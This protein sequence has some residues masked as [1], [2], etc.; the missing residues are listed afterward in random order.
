MLIFKFLPHNRIQL[1]CPLI[2]YPTKKQSPLL[3]NGLWLEKSS[4]Y[5]RP[6][7]SNKCPNKGGVPINWQLIGQERQSL[8][9]HILIVTLKTIN[10]PDQSITDWFIVIIRWFFVDV[11]ENIR[12]KMC[13]RYRKISRG[14]GGKGMW[15]AKG[16]PF[17]LSSCVWWAAFYGV[18]KRYLECNCFMIFV[19]ACCVAP[20]VFF[21]F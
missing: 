7:A 5:F 10:R 19:N 13:C 17:Q 8:E 12:N 16:P 11:A 3:K 21:F 2:V 9:L 14:D 6:I 4:L 20:F 1:F 15:G 18:I